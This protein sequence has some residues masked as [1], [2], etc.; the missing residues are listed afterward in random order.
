MIQPVSFTSDYKV[1]L[2]IKNSQKEQ[3]KKQQKKELNFW[4]FQ[5]CCEALVNGIDGAMLSSEDYSN[6]KS[7]KCS[8]T[9][10]VPDESDSV[11]ESYLLYNNIKFK[12]HKSEQ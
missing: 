7:F 2:K 5:R 3:T 4:R 12:K 6:G 10:H 9:L 1:K 8:T 11:V